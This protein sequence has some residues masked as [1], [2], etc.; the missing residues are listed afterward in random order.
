MAGSL[1]SDYMS[2][3]D[4]RTEIQLLGADRKMLREIA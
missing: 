3:R 4:D 1:N 2:E